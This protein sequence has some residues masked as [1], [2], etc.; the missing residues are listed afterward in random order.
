MCIHYL[1]QRF[2]DLMSVRRVGVSDIRNIILSR[3]TVKFPIDVYT[4]LVLRDRIVITLLPYTLI[5]AVDFPSYCGQM[6]Q[7]GLSKNILGLHY[8]VQLLANGYTQTHRHK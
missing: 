7:G 1:D 8:Q 6:T 3:I 5:C 4:A 2:F